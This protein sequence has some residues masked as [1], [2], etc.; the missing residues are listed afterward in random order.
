MVKHVHLEK[1]SKF[2]E[3]ASLKQRSW[4]IKEIIGLKQ[5]VSHKSGI[6]QTKVMAQSITPARSRRR[7]WRFS[8]QNPAL[9]ADWQKRE[10]E[11]SSL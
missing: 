10:H 4:N 7:S 11:K 2:N 3:I 6:S 9:F 1:V 5:R 8:P